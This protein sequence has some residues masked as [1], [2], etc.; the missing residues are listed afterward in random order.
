MSVGVNE[1][2]FTFIYLHIY[3][4]IKKREKRLFKFEPV[5]PV[6]FYETNY[7]QAKSAKLV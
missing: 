5:W 4:Y 6:F 1:F 2:F 3:T 7:F